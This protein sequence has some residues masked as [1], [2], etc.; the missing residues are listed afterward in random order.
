[1]QSRVIH[2]LSLLI[3]LFVGIDHLF[4][5]CSDLPYVDERLVLQMMII[6]MLQ[7]H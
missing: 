1:M 3:L 2:N 5:G 7:G 6:V 4:H